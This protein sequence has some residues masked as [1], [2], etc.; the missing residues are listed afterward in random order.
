MKLY[1]IST[2]MIYKDLTKIKLFLIFGLLMLI[3]TLLLAN[4]AYA[5]WPG[6]NG[7]I[8]FESN[9]D[10]PA[11]TDIYTMYPDGSHVTNLTNDPLHNSLLAKWSADGKK[12]VFQSKRAGGPYQIF[13]MDADGSN[14]TQITNNTADN[15]APSWSPDGKQIAFSSTL[16]GSQQYYIMNADGTD[17]RQ[18][19]F[20]NFDQSAF[21]VAQFTRDGN[22]LIMGILNAA[23]S[24][25][26]LYSVNVDGTNFYRITAD[27]DVSKEEY[28]GD[29]SPNNHRIAFMTYAISDVSNI[30]ISELSPKQD[31]YKPVALADSLQVTTEGNNESVSFSPDDKFLVIARQ[32][33]VDVD[34]VTFRDD[35]YVLN[36]QKNN[37]GTY[38]MVNIT[39]GNGTVVNRHPDWQ[40]IPNGNSASN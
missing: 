15:F 8:V 30:Y 28:M 31:V 11:R 2:S 7:L 29:L 17:V 6:K 1:A 33:G 23:G 40:P 13:V 24:T 37:K 25:D 26:A 27:S 21:L 38:D 22:K 12:I 19:T 34:H 36:L 3:T 39:N 35:I 16:S 18:I 9:R 32:P 4:P 5:A 20:A 10:H 14:I